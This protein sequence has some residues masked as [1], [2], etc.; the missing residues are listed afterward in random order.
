MPYNIPLSWSGIERIACGKKYD[1]LGQGGVS[2]WH[3]LSYL[4]RQK[5]KSFP[6]KISLF[7]SHPAREYHIRTSFFAIIFQL[8]HRLNRYVWVPMTTTTTFNLAA[9]VAV[10]RRRRR[11]GQGQRQHSGI[12]GGIGIGIGSSGSGSGGGSAARRR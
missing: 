9:A 10:Q 12:G 3:L 11:H 1:F 5:I 7:L 2:L 8:V 6:H 4:V